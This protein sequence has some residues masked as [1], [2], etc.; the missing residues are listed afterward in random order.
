MRRK[1][2]QAK[3]HSAEFVIT[4]LTCHVVGW[5]TAKFQ[6]LPDWRRGG[7]PDIE[8]CRCCQTYLTWH[9]TGGGG[10]MKC[11]CCLAPHVYVMLRAGWQA[12]FKRHTTAGEGRLDKKNLSPLSGDICDPHSS[13]DPQVARHLVG[14]WGIPGSHDIEIWGESTR[15]WRWINWHRSAECKLRASRVFAKSKCARHRS[16]LVKT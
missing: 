16:F 5:V 4:F 1:A 12:Y 14:G 13:C 15:T 9:A 3:E 2:Q 10:P 6:I 11:G 8:E 7:S